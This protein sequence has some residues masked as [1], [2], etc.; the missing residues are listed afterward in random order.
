MGSPLQQIIIITI[1]TSYHI[2]DVY[3]IQLQYI[4]YNQTDRDDAFIHQE[5]AAA[6]E[7]VL[8]KLNGKAPI[9]ACLSTEPAYGKKVYNMRPDALKMKPKRKK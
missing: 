8:R 3:K 1:Y 2:L 9:P 5:Y 4:A 6:L 7:M